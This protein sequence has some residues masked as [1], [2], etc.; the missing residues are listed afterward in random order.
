MPDQNAC[1]IMLV[2]NRIRTLSSWGIPALYAAAAI[3]LGMTLPRLETRYFSDLVSPI[4]T[5]AATAVYAS[6]ASGMISLTGIVFSL[7]FVMIQFS[8]TAYSPRIVWWMARD[9]VMSHGL[10]TFIATFLYAIAALTGV[11]RNSSGKVP[12]LS[13]WLV[14]V[15]LA[16]SV[17]MFVALV[18]RIQRLQV[19]QMLVF[20]GNHGRKVVEATY[21]PLGAPSNERETTPHDSTT[22]T[23]ILVHH[24]NP[25]YVQVI[26]VDTLVNLAS[27][28][29][30]VIEMIASVGDTVVEMTRLLQ[31]YGA[32]VKID[33]R[34]LLNAVE[35][36]EERTFEQDPKYAIRI[37]VDIAI[38]ALSAAINDPTTAV[39]SLDQIQ[40]LLLRLGMRRLEIGTYPDRA[41]NTRLL[42][43]FL[44]WDDL[45]CLAFDE[46]CAYGA[47]SIQV[48]RRMNALLADLKIALPEERQAGLTAWQARVKATIL[49]SYRTNEERAEA[50]KEDRQGLGAPRQPRTLFAVDP[51]LNNPT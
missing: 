21:P 39:Q 29:D 26:H 5:S 3:A 51:K 36:G 42:V 45:L 11:D 44:R 32:H 22:P 16:A 35:L 10:G 37:L 1:R 15:L 31:V 27:A 8:A 13:L 23:Q 33:E 9:P 43:P 19:N 34:K 20:V 30:G 6:I 49:S 12:F 18:Q 48:M 24:G 25:L 28:S 17:A 50:F 4:S 2:T 14:V 46:I 7:A 40:D 41:G 47:G 38:R